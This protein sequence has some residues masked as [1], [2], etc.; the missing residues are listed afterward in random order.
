MAHSICTSE[1]DPQTPYFSRL[2]RTIFAPNLDPASR[3]EQ[4]FEQE[5]A[6]FEMKVGFLSDIDRDNGTE[7]LVITHGSYKTL[8]QDSTIPLS[9]TYCRK[10]VA[11]PEGTLAVSDALAEGWDD[12]PA[13]TSLEIES[14]LGTTVLID[15][16]FYGTLCFVDPA[17]RDE[18]FLEEEKALLEL[19]SEWIGHMLTLCDG[20]SIQRGPV[21]T[22]DERSIASEDIDSMMDAMSSRT[23]RIVLK[24][25]VGGST[26]TS[27][28]TLERRMADES[29]NI[30]LQLYHVDLP[31]LADAGYITWDRDGD[32]V[33]RGPRY[34]EVE[35]LIKPLKEYTTDSFK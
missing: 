18:P 9:N 17:A 20:A 27:V 3:L 10:T 35:P 23:R 26:E 5:T 33:A 34:T 4:L 13:Y 8:K 2:W 31:R 7:R 16:Q 30:Q 1:Q 15:D 14:Y 29:D 24:T 25:L 28:E 22:L 21:D 12:D 19:Q 32:T 6:E 11:S